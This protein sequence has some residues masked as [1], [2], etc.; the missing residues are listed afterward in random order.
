M[1]DQDTH[2]VCLTQT[3]KAAHQRAVITSEPVTAMS[4]SSN[5][6]SN[7]VARAATMKVYC[8]R[9]VALVM[10][11]TNSIPELYR[12]PSTFCKALLPFETF[13]ELS[14][15]LFAA[16]APCG[17]YGAKTQFSSYF[18]WCTV[19]AQQGCELKLRV[20]SHLACIDT[21]S[22][23][24]VVILRPHCGHRP[25]LLVALHASPDSSLED[26]PGDTSH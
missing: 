12:E 26:L 21:G 19:V 14:S 18:H 3:V 11:S 5:S 1:E 7:T 13:Y 10:G 6:F 2:K 22:D 8:W 17:S 16:S 15:S 23:A 9:S 20:L 24:Y 25:L 4:N